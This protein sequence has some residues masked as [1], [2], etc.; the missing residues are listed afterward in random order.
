MASTTTAGFL[1]ATSFDYLIVGGGTAGLALAARLT[2]NP[3]VTVGVIEAGLD[4]TQDPNVLTPGFAPVMWDNPDY[5]WI[6]KTA[7]QTYGNGRVVGHPRGK[8]LGGSSAINFDYWTHASQRDI[9]D[10]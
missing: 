5:D 7:P 6:F 9:D 10:W 1:A 8:Q 3:Q 2:E 4:R